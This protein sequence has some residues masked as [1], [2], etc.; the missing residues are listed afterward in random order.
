[1]KS[2]NR[3]SNILI[4]VVCIGGV[5]LLLLAF[6]H[7]NNNRSE[8]VSVV[9]E[10]VRILTVLK[11]DDVGNDRHPVAGAVVGS[12]IAGTP[13][14]II[15]AAVG[16]SSSSDGLSKTELSELLGCTLIVRLPDKTTTALRFGQ[17]EVGLHSQ[18]LVNASLLRKGD[19][20][21]LERRVNRQSGE[22]LWYLWHGE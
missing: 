21:S 13:G 14:A 18:Q 12:L 2:N 11:K 7:T 20:I 15:G 16:N 1:M 19:I 8:E 10:E 6:S 17:S 5:S 22:V 9:V 4:G 3:A